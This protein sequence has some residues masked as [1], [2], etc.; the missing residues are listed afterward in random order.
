MALKI[1]YGGPYSGALRV[2]DGEP[3]FGVASLLSMY[4]V[5]AMPEPTCRGSRRGREASSS[6]N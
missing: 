4:L 5:C 2:G 1:G 3:P 6:Y